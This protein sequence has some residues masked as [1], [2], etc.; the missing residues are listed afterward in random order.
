MTELEMQLAVMDDDGA[1][2]A[3][4]TSPAERRGARLRVNVWSHGHAEQGTVVRAG[5]PCALVRLDSGVLSW[6]RRTR[7]TPA[8]D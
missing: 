7:I 1:G 6:V 3:I 8:G 4:T 5:F 2:C